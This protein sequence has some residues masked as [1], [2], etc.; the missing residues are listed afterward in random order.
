ML[1]PPRLNRFAQHASRLRDDPFRS[2]LP[3]VDF[4]WTM[5]IA[6][7]LVRRPY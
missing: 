6:D 3:D 1:W 5:E 2:T 4:P 7:E